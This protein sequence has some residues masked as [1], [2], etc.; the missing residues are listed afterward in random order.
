MWERTVVLEVVGGGEGEHA[1]DEYREGDEPDETRLVQDE[2]DHDEAVI[3][4]L[5]QE[6]PRGRDDVRVIPPASQ[7]ASQSVRQTVRQL[8][9]QL[10]SQSV[11]QLDKQSDS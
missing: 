11:S 9:S 8:V 10:V 7:S 3:A 2:E 5:L 6:G 4:L 1:G